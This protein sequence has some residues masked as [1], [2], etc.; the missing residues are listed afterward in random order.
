MG[1]LM[2]SI[3]MALWLVMPLFAQKGNGVV[4]GLLKE[5][6]TGQPVELATI[7]LHTSESQQVVTGGLTDSKGH[8]RIDQ[9]PQGSYYA[10]ASF[11][12]YSPVR[13][14]TFTLASNQTV[15]LG[16]L[17]IVEGE[18]LNEVVV[19]GRKSTFVAQLDRKVFHVGQDILSSSGS[20]SDLMQNIPSVE[21][22]MEGTVSLRGN[23]NVTIL[24]NG[25]PSAM[26]SAKTRGD[27]LNQLSAS[28]IER[29]EIIT[30]P[31]AEYKPDGVSGIINIVMKKEA[32][33]GLNGVL[34]GNIG[35]YG[36][37]NAGVN[38]NY[39][40]KGVNLFGGYT[41]R[42]D[43][44][45]RTLD[46][47]RTS[48]KELIHQTTY[49]LGRPVSHTIRLGMNANLTDQDAL[50]VAG[51]YN[52]RRFQRNEQVES[53]TND[54]EGQLMDF[55]QR[56]RD[57]FAKENMWEGTFRYTHDYGAGNSWGIDYTYSSE[58]ED[59]MNR[60]TTHRLSDST[61]DNEGVWDANYLHVGKLHGLHQ[62]SEQ[63]KLTFGY[64][65]E[66]L[67]AEQNYHLS[68]WDGTQFVPNLERSSDFTHL[69]MLHSLYATLEVSLDRWSLL[70]GLRGEY[71]HIENRLIS[72]DTIAKQ[73]YVNVYPTLHLSR[74]LNAHHELQFNYSLR[75]NRP[76]GDDMNPFAERIN[77]LSLQAGNPDLKPEKIH[78]LEAGWLWH[79]EGGQSLMSTLYYRYLTNQITKVSRYIADGVLLTTKENL[80]HSQSAGLE[81]IWNYPVAKWLSFNWNLNGFYNQIDATR[82]GYSQ[83]KS[84]FSWS[85]LLNANFTPLP[86]SLIQ[87]N[88]R[89]RG[90][91]LMPQGKM[92]SSCRI[93]LG[94]KYDIPS[95]NLSVLASVS[96]LFDTYRQ[97]YT[98]DTPE[99]K[100]QAEKRK[101]PR[102]IYF[103]LSWQ[104]GSGKGKKQQAK[105]EYDEGM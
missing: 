99:L 66:H 9:L 44:Y 52:R 55:Y 69:R 33:T 12:G 21:V 95:L 76:E 84:T 50:E 86:H 101:N 34:N 71:A 36:R 35:S 82:L 40:M 90:P 57:A 38:L 61:K 39:G 59:E 37:N 53:T 62:L 19:E 22:D 100:Q 10:E 28:S 4:I 70:A 20:A 65:L 25:K 79:S 30:N 31:S 96:D 93:N 97:S 56:Y 68:D 98:L 48:S 24:I 3:G 15:D 73:H 26:M 104:F 67:R 41:Y 13:S 14:E 64:E 72:A 32:G 77:P 16:T 80:D 89:Y 81:L 78:S 49:G 45:D 1:K 42:R 91:A 75:V 6:G 63:T 85:T 54:L 74:Q 92:R 27:A 23:E 7:A 17:Y 29:I 94:M 8:F 103:G 51:S 87:I 43:R 47:Q 83:K 58:A 18:Q 11:V 105:M 2:M 102:I 60:Y 5:K 88:A 46:D